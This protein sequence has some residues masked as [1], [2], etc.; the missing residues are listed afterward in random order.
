MHSAREIKQ[1][2]KEYYGQLAQ[3]GRS[4][5]GG[6]GHLERIGYSKE[7]LIQLNDDALSVG[8]G[9]GSPVTLAELREGEV[10]LDLGSGG[11]IDVFLAAQK[12]GPRGRAIG[13]DMTAAMVERARVSAKKMGITNVEFLLGEIESLPLDNASVD[14]VISNC[15]INLV[16]D[17]AKAFS[18]AFR[19]L[20]PGSRLIVSDIVTRGKQ[21][22]FFKGDLAAAWAGCLA[23]ALED[24]EYLKII[25]DAGFERVEIIAHSPI[26]EPA[27]FYSVT[28][29]GYKP[30]EKAKAC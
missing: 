20:K 19:V 3:L 8:A 29:R 2:V 4:C 7:E 18:E 1:I 12:V 10:V 13:I 25:A 9:C 22:N 21:A 15:V 5:C 16:P 23:G 28:V 27:G 6:T 24:K 30:T 11:G 17:K 14:V 26:P